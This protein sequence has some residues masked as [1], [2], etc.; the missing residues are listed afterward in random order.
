MYY[1][2]IGNKESHRCAVIHSR[3]DIELS[4]TG[5]GFPIVIF[6]TGRSAGEAFPLCEPLSLS[7]RITVQSETTPPFPLFHPLTLCS[8]HFYFFILIAN[9]V[10]FSP[11]ARLFLS[12]V[13]PRNA[14]H[15]NVRSLTCNFSAWKFAFF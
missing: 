4:L 12:R 10:C 13:S 1:N 2:N 3:V 11:P 8:L 9:S 5:C 7:V 14:F 15:R 6:R